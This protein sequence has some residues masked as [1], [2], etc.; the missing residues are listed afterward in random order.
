MHIFTYVL[1]LL[2]DIGCLGEEDILST[3]ASSCGDEET[4]V[5]NDGVDHLAPQ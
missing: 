2:L 1:S 5:D 3:D 4:G